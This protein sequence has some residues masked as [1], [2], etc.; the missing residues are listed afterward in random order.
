VLAVAA[1]WLALHNPEVRTGEGNVYPCS[2]AYDTVL[3]DADNVPGGEPPV[4][5][6]EAGS[7]CRDVGQAGFAEAVGVGTGSVLMTAL[8]SFTALR[9]SR[10]RRERTAS[11][12]PQPS[13]GGHRPLMARRIPG[14]GSDA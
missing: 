13:S 4:D 12:T 1:I 6:D 9:A 7:R 14:G 10:A 8:A 2:A 5:G 11:G 3:F